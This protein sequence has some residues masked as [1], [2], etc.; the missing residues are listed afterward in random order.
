MRD[1]K[2]IPFLTKDIICENLNDLVSIKYRN[3]LHYVTTAGSTGTP[4]GFY[5]QKGY[6]DPIEQ[7][8]LWFLWSKKNIRHNDRFIILRGCIVPNNKIYYYRDRRSRLVLSVY[9]LTDVNIEKMIKEVEKFKPN[10]IQAY[11]SALYLFSK[12]IKKNNY[13]WKFPLKAILTSSENL[14]RYQEELFNEIFHTQV[15]DLYGNAERT[16]MI[17]RCGNDSFHIIPFYGYTELINNNNQ[18]CTKENERGEVVSTGFNNYA[19]PF[20]RYKTQDIAINTNV[21]CKCGRNWKLIRNIEGRLQEMII[22]NTDRLIS[23]TAINMHSDVFD[24]VKQFQFHQKEKGKLDF[25]I[26]PELNYSENDTKRIRNALKE[27]LGSDMKLEIN[28]VSEISRTKAGKQ[29]FLIQE[30]SLGFVN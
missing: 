21:K 28:V 18:W 15:Y 11:P 19:M 25:N 16:V 20:I 7:A 30:L 24:N 26:I 14:Y 13:K 5:W 23:M 9:H 3:E 6:T 27:K 2:Q 29:R 22:T 12:W 8:F 10:V 4:T 17:N 1:I